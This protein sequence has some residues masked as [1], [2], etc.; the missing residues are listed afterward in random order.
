M[1]AIVFH[2]ASGQ[3]FF[4]GAALV[5]AALL[6]GAGSERRWVSRGRFAV[7]AI[8]VGLIAVSGTPFPLTVY[9]A[10]FGLSLAAFVAGHLRSAT[11]RTRTIVRV[12]AAA[13]WVVLVVWELPHQFVPAIARNVDSET[14]F[15]IGDS[16][17]AGMEDP[18]EV[19]WP[20][21]LA[22]DQSRAVRDFSQMGAT[23]RSALRQAEQIDG[24]G[25]VLLEI[26]GNDILGPSDGVS[27]DDFEAGLERLLAACQ[28]DG[29]RLVMLE[30]PLP[31]L[32][33]GVGAAQ[34]RQAR[35]YGAALLPK[36]LFL[37]VLTTDGAT[38][39]GI[40][41]SAEGHRMFAELVRSHV[42]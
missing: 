22:A 24:P 35:R 11:P 20:R 19:T 15:V 21:C 17:S 42:L 5:V 36:R 26:G 31:P 38:L 14:L 6:A 4:S 33:N 32:M 25:L 1:N 18:R 29:R 27:L 41:L 16:V 34:R 40:H 39:D 23:V 8:G 37:R 9:A 12:L 3:A 7:A 13:A 30:L 2:V 10:V 28:G